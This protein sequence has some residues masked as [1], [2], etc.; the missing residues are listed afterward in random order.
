MPGDGA[1]IIRNPIPAWRSSA[2]A[3]RPGSVD[4]GRVE[5][6]VQVAARVGTLGQDRRAVAGPA[7]IRDRHTAAGA[8]DDQSEV[9]RFRLARVDGVEVEAEA[10]DGPDGFAGLPG[11]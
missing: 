4:P 3:L 8:I 2:A 9:G 6:E 7:G 11:D 5:V 10:A 1:V